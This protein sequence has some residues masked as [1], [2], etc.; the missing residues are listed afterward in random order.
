MLEWNVDVVTCDYTVC[1]LAGILIIAETGKR[2]KSDS[3]LFCAVVRT[4][5]M[6]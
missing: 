5:K 2:R 4:S 3:L 6:L 1:P